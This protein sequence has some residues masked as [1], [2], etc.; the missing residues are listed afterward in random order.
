MILKRFVHGHVFAQ[1]S[2]GLRNN[3]KFPD[4]TAADLCKNV[5]LAVLL[6]SNS[7]SHTISIQPDVY[8]YTYIHNIK[9]LV[10]Q[11]K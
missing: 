2:P 1:S 8:L 6:G 7:N 11:K 4:N 5:S 3:D 9:K 10:G